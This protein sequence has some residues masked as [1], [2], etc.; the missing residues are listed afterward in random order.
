MIFF[1]KIYNEILYE[2]LFENR[3]ILRSIIIYIRRLI[4]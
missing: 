3:Q 2:I 1:Y 4:R